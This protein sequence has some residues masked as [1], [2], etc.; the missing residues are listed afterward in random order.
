MAKENRG[1]GACG[2]PLL[3]W[4]F[5]KR[6]GWQRGRRWNGFGRMGLPS[7]A[8]AKQKQAFIYFAVGEKIRQNPCH[9]CY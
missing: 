4:G 8:Q 7:A 1:R 9:P 6:Q 2:V 5:P 3:C